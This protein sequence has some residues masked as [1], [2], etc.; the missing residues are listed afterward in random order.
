[1]KTVLIMCFAKM[2]SGPAFT[3]NIA[4][5]FSNSGNRVYCIVSDKISNIEDWKMAE[6]IKVLYLDTGNRST[7]L[8]KT[9][10]FICIKNK[11]IDFLD[12]KIDISIQTFVHPWMQLINYWIKPTHKMAFLH[13]PYAHSGE[14][15][16]TA[17]M[18]FLQYKMTDE[19]IVLTKEFIPVVT[20]KYKKEMN[21]VYFARHGIFD[22][23]RNKSV[24]ESEFSY[25]NDNINF[26]FFGRIEEYKGISVLLDSFKKLMEKYDNISLTIAGSGDLTNYKEKINRLNNVNIVNRYIADCEIQSIFTGPNLILVLPYLDATQSGVI[27]IAIDFEVPIIASDSGGLREQLDDGKI[28]LFVKPGSVD[29]LSEKMMEAIECHHVIL[30]QKDLEKEFKKE[31]KWETIATKLVKEIE[32]REND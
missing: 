29:S 19:I 15:K 5:G 14:R 26:V 6:D 23:Y 12:D 8:K 10:S 11:I 18:A 27:P 24:I 2:G 16:I 13:D 3:L 9:F 4:K 20:Q 32:K 1:M 21:N 25:S 17:I 22:S 30:K 7:F 28:G 31:L